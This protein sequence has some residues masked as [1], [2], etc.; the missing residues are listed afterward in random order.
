MQ[1]SVK[2]YGYK[3][4]QQ[5]AA[6]S[7]KAARATLIAARRSPYTP[8][9]R[10]GGFRG[11]WNRGS[12]GPELKTIDSGSVGPN[13]NATAGAVLLINGV[14]TGTDYNTRT[15]RKTVI[16]SILARISFLTL[17]SAS[18]N[19]GE[20]VR[21]MLVQDT[22]P[23]GAA[24]TVANILQTATWDAPMN[25]DNRDRFRVLLDKHWTDSA[26]V[27]TANVLTQGNT[28]PSFRTHYL[29]KTIEVQY[30]GTGATI[31]SIAS[32]SIYFLY[33]SCNGSSTVN[34]ANFRVRFI[35][36]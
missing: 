5:A 11:Q 4:K 31:G 16:K 8:P 24:P 22:Q 2:K 36:G 27:Y 30:S 10:F 13:T 20:I 18:D 26:N 33:I 9:I 15:G 32:N 7:I 14:A 3:S 17:V 28:R 25:L 6:A 23:N 21:Y 12:I 1:R 29:K 35:D 34:Y 19:D